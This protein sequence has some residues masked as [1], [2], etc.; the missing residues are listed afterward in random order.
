MGDYSKELKKLLND[1]GC[2]FVRQGKGDHEIWHS[3]RTDTNF[4]VDQNIKSRHTA[5]KTLKDA[6]LRKQF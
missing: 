3:P 6:G 5:N 2:Y 4:P 1:A